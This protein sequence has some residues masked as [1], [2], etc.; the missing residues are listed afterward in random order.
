MYIYRLEEIT[1]L[2]TVKILQYI[3]IYIVYIYIYIYIQYIYCIYIYT[4][5]IYILC[6]YIYIYIYIYILPTGRNYAVSY[7]RKILQ[8]VYYWLE[9]ITPLATGVKSYS[10][11][12]TD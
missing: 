7:R 5:Y 8:Y 10:M 3:Y 9:E 11:Y 12:V 1:P 4:I 6:I 2:V